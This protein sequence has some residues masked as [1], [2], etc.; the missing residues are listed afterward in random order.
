MS[1]NKLKY[2]AIFLGIITIT[3]IIVDSKNEKIPGN[4][5]YLRANDAFIKEDFKDALEQYKAA[6]KHD[7]ENLYFLEG[8][9]RSLMSLNRNG[10][11]IEI[12]LEVIKLNENFET[13]Y[14]NLGILYDRSGDYNKAIIYYSKALQINPELSKGMHWLDRLLR[15]VKKEPSNISQRL[16]YLKRQ[17]L[18]P[19]NERVLSIPEEDK[20]QLNYEM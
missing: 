12:F 3:W 16:Y 18:L 6:I 10:D 9:A 14:S 8:Q 17:M 7:P 20:K 4:K 15:N 2:I 1:Y 11:A 13:A 19:E 5:E